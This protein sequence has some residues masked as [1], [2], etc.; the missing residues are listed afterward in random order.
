MCV[1]VCEPSSAS[2]SWLRFSGNVAPWFQR[3]SGTLTNQA[4]ECLPVFCRR[5]QGQG[6]HKGPPTPAGLWSRTGR[7]FSTGFTVRVLFVVLLALQMTDLSVM[8]SWNYKFGT[9]E[10]CKESLFRNRVFWKSRLYSLDKRSRRK[11]E[12]DKVC[13][14]VSLRPCLKD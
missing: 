3:G 5:T 13:V 1:Y 14:C 6:L 8:F 7:M 12:V 4:N 11:H 9:L 10:Q 2:H